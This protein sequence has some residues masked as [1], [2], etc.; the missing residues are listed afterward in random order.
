MIERIESAR[1]RAEAN[2]ALR[3]AKAEI[4]RARDAGEHRRA[5]DLSAAYLE[6]ARAAFRRWAT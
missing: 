5:D 3:E 4:I 6:A 2:E 1:S